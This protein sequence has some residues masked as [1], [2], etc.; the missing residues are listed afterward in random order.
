M[1][2]FL[3]SG[4]EVARHVQHAASFRDHSEYLTTCAMDAAAL[5][6]QLRGSMRAPVE[7]V[8]QPAVVPSLRQLSAQPSPKRGDAAATPGA[9]IPFSARYMMQQQQRELRGYSATTQAHAVQAATSPHL[10]PG[11]APQPAQSQ[12][13][14]PSPAAPAAVSP[15]A[16]ASQ[17]PTF[18]TRFEADEA[19]R[20]REDLVQARTQ[21]ALQEARIRALE[22]QV[23]QLHG[24]LQSKS[25]AAVASAGGGNGKGGAGGASPQVLAYIV[26]LEDTVKKLHASGAQQAQPR[27]RTS[28]GRDRPTFGLRLDTTGTPGIGQRT[29]GLRQEVRARRTGWQRQS[30]SLTWCPSIVV[31]WLRLLAGIA[32]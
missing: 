19:K 16:P 14:A 11:P 13:R 24:L 21:A 22:H 28:K 12:R 30:L 32:S 3:V 23:E 26:Q 20:L 5:L 6:R 2:S 25:L 27:Q 15:T 29:Q 1:S 9:Q 4:G 31:V 17:Q 10:S 8:S 7:P 18:A